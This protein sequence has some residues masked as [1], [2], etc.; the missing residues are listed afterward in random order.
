MRPQQCPYKHRAEMVELEGLGLFLQ[1]QVCKHPS[2][3]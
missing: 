3:K 2:P 1:L